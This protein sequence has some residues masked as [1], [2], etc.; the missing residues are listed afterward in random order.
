MPQADPIH[1]KLALR[2]AVW[3][4]NRTVAYALHRVLHDLGIPLQLHLQG[5]RRVLRKLWRRRH[6]YDLMPLM[7]LARLAHAEEMAASRRS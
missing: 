1:E 5:R 6:G 4:E 3:S 7:V 2:A